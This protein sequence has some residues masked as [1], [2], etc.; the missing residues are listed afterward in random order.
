MLLDFLASK[1]KQLLDDAWGAF[2]VGNFQKAESLFR[3]VMGSEDVHA[4]V[5]DLA[6]AHN[7]IAAI[8]FTHKDFF[9]SL[10]WYKEALD[11]LEHYYNHVWPHYLHWHSMHDRPAMRAL[12]G[13]GNLY[14]A[15]SDTKRAAFYYQK[16]K[17]L[18]EADEL[19]A[20]RYL[21]AIS[22]GKKYEELEAI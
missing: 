17:D 8:H 9:E 18:D 21:A 3:E 4:T 15:R 13:L 11:L 20:A 22:G 16:L 10:R 6:D 12:M 19:G 7:G 2:E 1:H 5:F 14:Y